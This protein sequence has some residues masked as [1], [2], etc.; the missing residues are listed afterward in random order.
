MSK[1]G[2]INN[3]IKHMDSYKKLPL[4]FL[5]A[6]TLALLISLFALDTTFAGTI[7]TAILRE[8]ISGNQHTLQW[9]TTGALSCF[10][11]NFDAGNET[12]A[13]KVVTQT[14][15][16]TYWLTCMGTDG[17]VITS[18]MDD[19]TVANPAPTLSLTVAPATIVKGSSAKISWMSSHGWG[20]SN[21]TSCTAS[22]GWNGSKSVVGGIETV[23][24]TQTTGYKLTCTGPG[25]SVDYDLTI[26]VTDPVATSPQ[27]IP[28][29][30]LSLN[31]GTVEPALSWIGTNVTSC[32]GVNFNTEGKIS[33]AILVIPTDV[34]TYTINCTGPNGTASHSATFN[35]PFKI[36]PPTV[37]TLPVVTPSANTPKTVDAPVVV[38][39]TSNTS[40]TAAQS[41]A[42]TPPVV[43][44]VTPSITTSPVVAPTNTATMV[45]PTAMPIAANTQA[46]LS[47]NLYIGTSGSDVVVLQDILIR[48]KFLVPGYNTGFFG[49]LTRAAVMR[50]QQA[51]GVQAT[52]YVGPLTRSELQ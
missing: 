24:P 48:E 4:R 3:N 30:S 38:K 49:N 20:P 11:T 39:T 32:T 8:R 33:G 7:P 47:R 23:T 27:P 13:T 50:F 5:G 2:I 31:T 15:P 40:A 25:G 17:T 14:T 16:M 26:T 35:G 28:S 44:V 12:Y 21:A 46:T 42:T 52:G 43:A 51:H 41:A 45:I 10:G 6:G 19:G 18:G 29:V 36:T 1:C 9:S 34:T 37:V 22:G